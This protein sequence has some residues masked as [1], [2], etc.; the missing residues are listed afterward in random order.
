M[1]RRPGY[2]RD[3]Q[4]SAARA[5]FDFRRADGSMWWDES[6]YYALTMD[7][8]DEIEAAT[9]A[10]EQLVYQV[11]ADAIEQPPLLRALQIPD[12][13]HGLV[14]DSW[15][16]QERHLYGRMDFAR[17]KDGSLKLLEYNGDTP[18]ALFEAAVFQW[19]WLETGKQTGALPRDAD[20]FNS[21]HDRLI[22]AFRM[23]GSREGRWTFAAL[24]SSAED[25]GTVAYLAD[26]A[27]QAGQDIQL[28]AM[29]EIGLADGRVFVD[30]QDR[31]ITDLFKLYPW[32]DLLREDFGLAMLRA[33]QAREIRVLE[34]AWK[35]VVSN[36][37]LLPLLWRAAKG[38]PNLLPSYFALDVEQGRAPSGW[39]G[40]KGIVTK[41]L[42]G[43]EGAGTSIWLGADDRPPRATP[44][45][46]PVFEPG[47]YIDQAYSELATFDGQ[48]PVLGSWTVAGQAAGLGIREDSELVTGGNARFVPHAIVG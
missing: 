11:V 15:R 38:H 6:A 33:A 17:G 3:W 42:W 24:G 13:A 34:P 44:A 40:G 26:T 21:I 2:A 36:K 35:M 20:Q 47:W 45:D 9:T 14:R 28:L 4:A 46:A 48:R 8:V 22:E 1:Q 32:E 37:G 10:I 31:P 41:A 39:H 7:E 5:N 23:L 19:E 43:R 12:W 18:T 27:L 29:H 30:L 25:L 16:G